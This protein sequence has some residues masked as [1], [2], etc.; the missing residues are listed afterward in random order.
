MSRRELGLMDLSN[1]VG[2]TDLH[3]PH[4]KKKKCQQINHLELNIFPQ[5][6]E[7]DAIRKWDGE[8]PHPGWE[9]SEGPSF[10]RPKRRPRNW[11]EEVG[12]AAQEG[13]AGGMNREQVGS[14]GVR[15]EATSRGRAGLVRELAHE[16]GDQR[17][18]GAQGQGVPSGRQAAPIP[19]GRL[20]VQSWTP[21]Q[22][23]ALKSKAAL[24]HKAWGAGGLRGE[25]DRPTEGYRH[26]APSTGAPGQG[27]LMHG[28]CL[29]QDARLG[30]LNLG[31]PLG[32]G[33]A[34]SPGEKPARPDTNPGFLS[35]ILHLVSAA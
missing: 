19:G 7:Q 2:E 29:T 5:E 1:L 14:R 8:G 22:G 21:S 12:G 4:Q 9:A 31:W 32:L 10:A 11:Q 16:L 15:R 17:G 34:E 20:G 6:K 30:R 23:E 27:R 18:W 26:P 25:G 35:P 3:R 13:K 28:S 24:S 33:Q